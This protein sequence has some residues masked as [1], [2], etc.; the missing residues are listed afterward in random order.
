MILKYYLQLIVKTRQL[1]KYSPELTLEPEKIRRYVC[2]ASVGEWKETH[3]LGSKYRS[4][5]PLRSGT[6][7]IDPHSLLNTIIHCGRQNVWTW[8]SKYLFN[9]QNKVQHAQMLDTPEYTKKL[10]FEM[11]N[12]TLGFLHGLTNTFNSYKK[13]V[14][15]SWCEN[16]TPQYS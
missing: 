9:F 6:K 11:C 14:R 1:A 5:L 3:Q 2:L 15:V 13:M 8:L 12:F 10:E 4:Y 7:L 16:G